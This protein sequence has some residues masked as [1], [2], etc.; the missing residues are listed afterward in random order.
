M[1]SPAVFV[2][3]PTPPLGGVAPP[4]FV[5]DDPAP[6]PTSGLAPPAAP[7]ASAA[8][9][10]VPD[11]PG[12]TPVPPPAMST[13]FP[14]TTPPPVSVAPTL[15]PTVAPGMPGYDPTAGGLAPWAANGPG[16]LAQ[17][18]TPA[19]SVLDD[20]GQ[21]LASGF[22]AGFQEDLRNKAR[23]A[24]GETFV[25]QPDA[26]PPVE[27]SF[28]NEFG[29]G[30]GGS[31]GMLAGGIGGAAAGTAVGGPIGGLVGA[32][33]G[34]GGA[35]VIQD[36]VPAYDAAI[37]NNKTHDQAVDYAIIHA[38]ATGAISGA[39]APLFAFTPFKNAIGKILF[40]A[41]GAQPAS[42][43]AVRAGVPLVMG[44]P[45]PSMGEF[46]R[47]AG[48][49]IAT[50]GMFAGGHQ[51][52]TAHQPAPVA[53][54]VNPV[55]DRF[56]RQQQ[57][58][59]DQPSATDRVMVG[60][61][62]RIEPGPAQPPVS[63]PYGGLRPEPAPGTELPALTTQP[64]ATLGPTQPP[65]VVTAEGPTRPV[66]A[67]EVPV[68]PPE[69][70][71][72]EVLP[73]ATEAQPAA[74]SPPARLSPEE[75]ATPEPAGAA[76]AAPAP[77]EAQRVQPSA[78]PE[79]PSVETGLRPSPVP[80]E[81]VTIPPDD[82]SRTTTG[83]PETT[84][85]V[86]EANA[87]VVVEPALSGSGRG[88]SDQGVSPPD[89]ARAQATAEPGQARPTEP[90]EPAKRA[91]TKA[92]MEALDK[93][94]GQA[95]QALDR[96][97]TPD[98]IAK[99]QERYNTA[100][101]ARNAAE[102]PPVKGTGVFGSG[103]G[104]REE[105][106]A[107][108]QRR[109]DEYQAAV[110]EH[111]AKIDARIHA[112]GV[113]PTPEPKKAGQIFS[114]GGGWDQSVVQ[115][116]DSQGR[117]WTGNGNVM[118]RGTSLDRAATAALKRSTTTDRPVAS[119]GLTK[120]VT[121][122]PKGDYQPVTWER[123]VT[124]TDGK[125][126]VIGTKPD[127]THV[128]VQKPIYDALHAATGMDGTVVADTRTGKANDPRIF[129]RNAA[130]ETIG[131]GMPI[132]ARQEQARIWARGPEKPAEPAPAAPSPETRTAPADAWQDFN[133]AKATRGD[134]PNL[135]HL[136]G[137]DWASHLPVNKTSNQYF[138]EAE[139]L[140][141]Q[142][143][144]AE[145][146]TLADRVVPGLTPEM[147]RVM[148][149]NTAKAEQ[150]REG[151]IEVIHDQ[152]QYLAKGGASEREADLVIRRAI[153]A[154]VERGGNAES[155]LDDAGVTGDQRARF[156]D[157]VLPKAG[158]AT[159]TRAETETTGPRAETPAPVSSETSPQLQ[160]LQAT[161]DQ[162][163]NKVV[164]TPADTR[165][166]ARVNAQ[167]ERLERSQGVTRGQAVDT[168][169][170]LQARR[171][172]KPPLKPIEPS[173]APKG[174]E[175]YKYNDGTSVY[176][177]VFAEAG[178]DPD[179]AV[180]KPIA[181]QA[182]VI[183]DHMVNKFGFTGVEV[184]GARGEASRV[185]Q[186]TAVQA[187]LDMTRAMTD[188]MAGMGLPHSAASLNG[189][190]KLI[191][192][193]KGSRD[194]YG[195]YQ[196][197][198]GEIRITGGANSFGH[199][200]THAIDHYLVQNYAAKANI[201]D[202][203]SRVARNSGPLD[204]TN[205]VGAAFAKV[206]NTMFYEDAALAA[207]RLSLETTAQKTN[208]LG[209]PTVAAVEARRQLDLLEAGGSKLRIQPSEF[210]TKSAQFQPT[211]AGYYASV[212]EMLARAHEAYMAWRMETD[213]KD[214]RGIVMPDEAY[215]NE[216][217]RQLK[218]IYPKQDERTAIFAAFDEL[219][220][221]LQKEQALSLG[222]PAGSFANYG[223]SDPH[224]YP[225]T[226]PHAGGSKVVRTLKAEIAKYSNFTRNL[227]RAWLYD[228]DRP[229]PGNRTL[230][231][232]IADHFRAVT[233]SG[234][235]LMET[236]IARAPD[237]AK[238]ILTQIMDR[239]A[240]A[241]GEGRYTPMNFEESVRVRSR[242][243]TRRFGNMLDAQ[244]LD[245]NTMT[246]LEGEQLRHIL[247]TGETK[248]QGENIP[249]GIIKT[250]GNVRQL[251]NEVWSA[252][253]KAG[254]DIGYAKNGY[255]PRMYDQARIFADPPG[256][257]KAAT[258]MHRLIFDQEIGPAG[259][260][261]ERLLERWTGLERTNKAA[262]DPA[263]QN[264][265]KA[266]N[267]NLRR[268][269]EIEANLTPTPAERAELAQLKIDAKDLAQNAHAPLRDHIADLAADNWFT[270]LLT[271]Q[272]YDF[273]TTG[274][275]GQY[276]NARVLPPEADQIMAKYM[277]Q[278]PTDAI[279]HYFHA[280]ARRISYAER[281]GAQGEGEWLAEQW[282]KL[283]HIDGVDGND[284]TEFQRIVNTATG[285]QSVNY[286]RTQ[287]LHNGIHA[288]ASIALMPRV[289]WSSI[290][291][292]MNTALA[293]GSA[294]AG[295]KT[296]AYQFGSL[297]GRASAQER[298]ELANFL[299]VTTSAMH[300]SIMLSRMSADYSDSP[301]INQLMTNY[302]RTTGLTQLTNAQRT[303]SAA[304][305]NWLLGKWSRDY[306]DPQAS[307][308][309]RHGRDDASR[310]FKELGVPEPM[311]DEFAKWM[312]GLG[313]NIP[314]R[315]VLQSGDPMVGLYGLAVRRLVDRSIQDPYKIDRAE[316]AS[317]PIT[318]L[319]FQLMSFGYQFQRNILVPAMMRVEHSYGRTKT[320]AQARGAGPVNARIQGLTM[321]GGTFV[322]AA[323][324][325]GAMVAA[326]IP[327][328]MLR[329]W[330][331]ARDQWDK[332]AEDDTLG[333]YI[334]D[335]AFQ[336]TGL[337]GTL[338]PLI[339]LFSNLKYQADLTSLFDGAGP[340][341][342][343]KNLLDVA[344][345]LQTD[346]PNTNTRLHNAVRG[347]WNLTGVPLTAGGMAVLGG[348]MGPVTRGVLGPAM[349]YV[350]SPSVANQ[351]A[352]FVAGE[353]GATRRG[354]EP[355]GG[356]RMGGV[357]SIPTPKMPGMPKLGGGGSTSAD[358]GGGIAGS[359]PYGIL[360]DFIAP[361]MKKIGPLIAGLPG[362]VKIG[363]LTLG[364]EVG[365]K[366]LWDAGEP[367]R[368]QPA[369]EPKATAA[370]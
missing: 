70:A 98:E 208:K 240:A 231:V 168:E 144:G 183:S 314:N 224:H 163:Q 282:K 75:P 116:V 30:I 365:L 32:A 307:T 139:R 145:P 131:V 93:R 325:A 272:S 108:A 47:G 269:R 89:T 222:Q 159:E 165:T 117:P 317:R 169:E 69:P 311:H 87:G 255:F 118:V 48:M 96:A 146:T 200:W 25:T 265:M 79:A 260:N 162:L 120:V 64:T 62:Q 345:I 219:H 138:A 290:A 229:D 101:D 315:T 359:V 31:G 42:G 27:R 142:R 193:P 346:S 321:G 226:V 141:T 303:A 281:F 216:T 250:A 212:Y 191:L 88:G 12:P 254:L 223:I 35:A 7:A 214:P 234:H 34:T 369:P 248:Y 297:M 227:S 115:G 17:G 291:E 202:L 207:R 211:K 360:D 299:N 8:P 16:Q 276:L 309:A 55:I 323:A 289:V 205:D 113:D 356:S 72:V 95:R 278:Q 271:G 253:D 243:W 306:L 217:N 81:N 256:F 2:P 104:T 60:G 245:P 20:T 23:M 225:V 173:G 92:E 29:Y 274:P 39:T 103:G 302:Y 332:H 170:T 152:L 178:H 10:F 284:I 296:F 266:L 236:M 363:A 82:G 6:A 129:V 233:F 295:F 43:A 51:I 312:V 33:L 252:S 105:A 241:P 137:S 279:P 339:Q 247:T 94:L 135:S 355:G 151:G 107:N 342:I 348:A 181:W 86:G 172:G 68:A 156:S 119:E 244:G 275:S 85:A 40:Q 331:F 148:A 336:R 242:E 218:M 125:T 76:T 153:A 294:T 304:A 308:S 149:D 160:K 84:A 318:G 157:T 67:A 185:D 24:R 215:I 186:H 61:P 112:E 80:P 305:S 251:L 11:E 99:A 77:P 361:A 328:T 161:R 37:R 221:A 280:A 57:A 228:A 209:Q 230:G 288:M 83:R 261:P 259:D 91:V 130:G 358:S 201:N 301:K 106:R 249:L 147:Q 158:G 127:G 324:M 52:A 368:G 237:A 133:Q 90:V 177:S 154:E 46:I 319:A 310:W 66:G 41:L 179:V 97:V 176:R 18:V 286:G 49:D 5:P 329:Q 352:D 195:S 190:L 210:R 182:K 196:P 21:G 194:Y 351:I 362:P 188:A 1:G 232:R 330:L 45:L 38:T 277:H 337:N 26:A 44:E 174:V 124:D 53:P 357:P 167:I 19:P 206:I 22:V 257:K 65:T 109:E 100:R 63:V 239:I 121:P 184:I 111:S 4:V 333:E 175:D 220:M 340:N 268:Q 343:G 204:V 292:P 164:Q 71:R 58:P 59:L 128:T 56:A 347:L 353:K 316:I 327:S 189:R 264:D 285:R 366:Q 122:D 335:L 110:A 14:Q 350:T 283:A 36:L 143:Y 287:Q 338:D 367:F 322:H 171:G 123:Q 341:Y 298:T 150:S 132:N 293:T 258:E 3:D 270:K 74:V 349:Q 334:R 354:S 15:S 126:L 155:F 263:L 198:T 267:A 166:L 192:E 28:A 50:G 326:Q 9:V 238:P 199:E 197:A 313:G 134:F 187:M 235:G 273:D 180:N 213:G 73:P 262:A 78:V 114:M 320:E 203:L 140:M 54:P 364:A 246:P 102:G 370:H 136:L 344:R 13:I 300:D